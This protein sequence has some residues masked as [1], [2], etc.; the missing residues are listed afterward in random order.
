LTGF[1][2]NLQNKISRKFIQLDR[3]SSKRSYR[4][5]FRNFRW[6]SRN[7]SRYMRFLD[8]QT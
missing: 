2:H 1:N 5:D 7:W 4:H 8:V 6:R 3:S